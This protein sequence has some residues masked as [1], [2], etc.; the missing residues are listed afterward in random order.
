MTV[1]VIQME[2]LLR[3]CVEDI[4]EAIADKYVLSC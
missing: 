3:R 4:R 2:L 1:V